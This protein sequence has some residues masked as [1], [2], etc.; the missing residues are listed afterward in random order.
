MQ[1][2]RWFCFF[3]IL[4][5][6]FTYCRIWRTTRGRFRRRTTDTSAS[7]VLSPISIIRAHF[8]PHISDVYIWAS[9]G[10]TT[11][12]HLWNGSVRMKF[13]YVYSIAYGGYSICNSFCLSSFVIGINKKCLFMSSFMGVRHVHKIVL[14]PYCCGKQFGFNTKLPLHEKHNSVRSLISPSHRAKYLNI[15]QA[16]K[17]PRERRLN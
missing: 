16:M 9:H 5:A 13:T 3:L 6:C 1:C 12:T 10:D 4:T 14:C 7:S 8:K 17:D 11:R 15:L 2:V